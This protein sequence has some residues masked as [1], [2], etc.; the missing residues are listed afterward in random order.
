MS[1]PTPTPAAPLPAATSRGAQ[2]ALCVFLVVLVGLLAF[3]GYGNRLGARPTEPAAV[4]LIDLNTADQ[5]EIAQVP[6]VGPKL[7]EA[8]LDHRRLH[9]PFKSVDE[10]KNVRGVG[11]VTFERIRG[12]FR[13]GALPRSLM[14]EPPPSPNP[15]TQG[16][17]PVAPPRSAAAMKKIQPGE[18]PINVNTASADE[19]MRLPAV[20]PVMA[21][22]I[23][24]TRTAAPFQ[25][26][27]D[28]RKVKGIG[29][30]TLDK[31]RPFVV[32]K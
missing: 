1:A 10:L 3:R 22:N 8:I 26:V 2:V 23:I 28:L 6:G 13:V 11:P 15:Q 18:P 20:G 30:K 14:A 27:E 17:A 24:A 12:Q 19:L 32:V 21:Q 25:S 7:A 16:P 9:G 4:D 5:P 29:P 31:L